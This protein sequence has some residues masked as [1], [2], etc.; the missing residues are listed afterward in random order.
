[1]TVVR[2][3][4]EFNNLEDTWEHKNP[5]KFCKKKSQFNFCGACVYCIYEMHRTHSSLLLYKHK[6]KFI[7]LK[8]MHNKIQKIK[9][10]TAVFP[11]K[12]ET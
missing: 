2:Q 3:N 12:Y 1:M 7:P 6:P 11:K 4:F 10:S 8:F 5:D 9:N